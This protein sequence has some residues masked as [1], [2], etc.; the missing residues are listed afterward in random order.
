[1]NLYDKIL[2][3]VIWI[4]CNLVFFLL[5]GYRFF[6]C[7]FFFLGFLYVIFVIYVIFINYVDLFM[8]GI[9][10]VSVVVGVFCG[11]LIM[12]CLYCGLFLVGLGF[13]FFIGVVIFFVILIFYYVIFVWILF[14]V[15]FGLSLIFSLLILRW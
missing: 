12:F 13:G 5:V 4:I 2:F 11:F 8:W 3:K 15:F 1:M 9:V 7:S 14:G 6:K 10:V